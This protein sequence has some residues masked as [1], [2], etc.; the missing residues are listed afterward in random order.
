MLD[1]DAATFPGPRG[2]ATAPLNP[3]QMPTDE[4]A[5]SR[6]TT[7]RPAWPVAAAMLA[8][9]LLAWVCIAGM[10]PRA[11]VPASAPSTVFSA[12]RAL[13]HLPHIAARPHPVGTAANAETR[14]YLVDALKGL[15]YEVQVQTELGVS[16]GDDAVGMVN[17]IVARRPGNAGGRALMLSAHYD[18]VPTGPGA[19]DDGASVAAVLETLRA[20]QSAPPS[21]NGLIVL[22][23]DGEEA[24][25][26]GAEAFVSHHPWVKDVGMV[27]NF[28]YRGDSG[29]TLMFETSPGNG[30]LISA[31]SS[32]PHPLGTSLMYEIYKRMPNGTDFTVFKRAGLAGMN[33]APIAN[34]S[35]YHTALDRIANVDARSVQDQGDTMLALVRNLREAN[36]DDLASPDRVYF[37]LPGIGLVNYPSPVT[38]LVTAVVVGLLLGV[39]MAGV[40]G[41]H[42]RLGRTVAGALVL[43]CTAVLLAIGTTLML[44]AI[45]ALHPG[46]RGLSDLYNAQ[47]YWIAFVALALSA[48]CA[49]YKWLRRWFM[50]MELAVGD[51]LAWAFLLLGC[52]W[53]M[54]GASFL[55]AWPLAATLCAW[56]YLLSDGAT[57]RTPNHRVLVLFLGAMP[58]IVLFSTFLYLLFMALT[59]P[60]AAIPVVACVLLLGILYPVLALMQASFPLHKVAALVGVGFLAVGEF[61]AGS[62]TQHPHPV[63]VLYVE[64]SSTG[65]AQW[66]SADVVLDTW[67]KK[68]FDSS[69]VRRKLP[70]WYG[71]DSRAYWT[72]AAPA[73][74]LPPPVI[75]PVSDETRGTRRTVEFRLKSGRGAREFNVHAIGV[76]VTG[77][78]VDGQPVAAGPVDDW[79]LAAYAMPAEGIDVKLEVAAGRPFSINVFDSTPGL[80]FLDLSSRDSKEMANRSET[81]D[82]TQSLTTYR[83]N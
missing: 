3:S 12:E 73:S 17:N 42:L 32:V 67:E 75:T 31:F 49:L 47:W 5:A 25:L 56:L 7:P 72:S 23:T 44:A 28:E 64:D 83:F 39:V 21:R 66:L 9:L 8:L 36:L 29:P 58:G 26:L 6:G 78:I 65:N 69:S 27:L 35:S 37:D 77:A 14:A 81:S 16:Q 11:P 48:F 74:K 79:S 52:A 59:T 2:P 18:S 1:S 41:G 57:R 62:S 51:A 20:L 19:A 15:G 80:P 70:E 38:W 24:G 68:F 40:R 43:P 10:A 82:T 61:T 53:F 50:P 54:P 55:L 34:V 33:F 76:Q 45:R 22:F 60:L 46:Y 30:K 71:T 63:N 13:A 4:G